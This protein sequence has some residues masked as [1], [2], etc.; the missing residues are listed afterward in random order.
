LGDY[1]QR[2]ALIELWLWSAHKLDEA[3]I[4]AL[5]EEYAVLLDIAVA[6]LSSSGSGIYEPE[7][8]PIVWNALLSLEF[9]EA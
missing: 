7:I 2:L 3:N 9:S 6:F 4:K 5:I 1:S 8:Q